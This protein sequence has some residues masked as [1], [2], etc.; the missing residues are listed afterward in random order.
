MSTHPTAKKDV[1][2]IDIED[3]ITSIIDKVKNASTQIVALV[4]P[5]RIGALQSVVNLKLLNRAAEGAKKRIVLITND[6]ALSAL[7]AGVAIPIAK[8]L[9]SKPEVAESP[10]LSV[11][12]DDV[13]DGDEVPQKENDDAT[14]DSAIATSALATSATPASRASSK[15]SPIVIPN[16]DAFRNKLALIIGGGLLLIGFLVWALVFAPHANVTVVAKTTPYGVNKPLLATADSTLDAA[17]G[18]I[19]ATVKEVKKTVSADFTATGKKDVGEKAAGTVKFS[20]DSLSVIVSGRGNIPAGTKLTHAASGLVYV[21]DSPVSLTVSSSSGTTTITAV[22]SGAKYNGATGS[23]SGAGS[24]VD[25]SIVSATTGGTDKTVTVV[26]EQ[27]AASAREKIKTA[28]ADAVKAD[29]KKQFA[30]D[31]VVVDESF[32]VTPGDPSVTPA[33]G[34]EATS[35]KVSVE[36]TYTMIG[37]VRNDIRTIIEKDLTK[38]IGTIPNQMIYDQGLDK[39]KFTS[40]AKQDSSYKVNLVTTGYVGPSINSAELAKKLVGKREM[41][42]T[43]II[44]NYEG[45]KSVDV[46]F[47]PFWVSTAPSAD[48]ITIKFDIENARNN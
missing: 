8:N 18:T 7:A 9:Q 31:L 35:G 1:I 32:T 13:I 37:L 41:E 28:D 16:F 36:T 33:V 20:T 14:D 48:K 40:F 17:A 2:Y 29:L 45:I 47:S 27:D 34:Q 10:V 12:N 23:V 25:A 6:H 3:D 30:S 15:K 42:I 43:Q 26:S 38:Q 22:E 11:D 4:P 21:T 46:K 5:K 19:K 39:V 24:G 44:K